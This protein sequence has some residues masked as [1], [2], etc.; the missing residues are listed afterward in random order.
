MLHAGLSL[1]E[2]TVQMLGNWS[3]G[4][5]VLIFPQGGGRFRS[6]LLYRRQGPLRPLAGARHAEDFLAA[7][8]PSKTKNPRTKFHLNAWTP[9]RD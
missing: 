5:A 2:D 3:R 6:Y 1:P 4:E 7:A 9:W 8:G